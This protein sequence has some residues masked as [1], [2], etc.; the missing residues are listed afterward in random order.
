MMRGVLSTVEPARFYSITPA[1][2][3]QLETERAAWNRMTRIV[4][5][6]LSDQR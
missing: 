4:A 3:R 2:R 6:L 5:T 1:A